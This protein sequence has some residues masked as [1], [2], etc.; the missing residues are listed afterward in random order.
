MKWKN[1]QKMTGCHR[2]SSDE[3]IVFFCYS[4]LV[5]LWDFFLCVSYLFSQYLRAETH[6]LCKFEVKWAE[7]FT[8]FPAPKS[9][10][11]GKLQ[12]KDFE[13]TSLIKGCCT[14]KC[15]EQSQQ[16]RNLKENQEKNLSLV[17][18]LKNH[19]M[20]KVWQFCFSSGLN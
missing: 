8:N 5:F 6:R 2:Q 19:T 4:C 20:E 12:W 16:V 3:T 9:K 10:E 13:N 18:I 15:V 11:L 17:A 14:S 1:G 7:L